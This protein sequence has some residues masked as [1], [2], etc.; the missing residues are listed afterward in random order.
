MVQTKE[1]GL[2]ENNQMIDIEQWCRATLQELSYA[3]LDR[4]RWLVDDD[5]NDDDGNGGRSE[6]C[7]WRHLMAHPRKPFVSAKISRK[8]L[9]QAKL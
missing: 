5:D 4:Q 7:D 8:S 1:D 2:T 3:A 6:K 9:T